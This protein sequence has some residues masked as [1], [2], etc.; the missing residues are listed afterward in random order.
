MADHPRSSYVAK[1]LTQSEFIFSGSAG[2]RTPGWHM[3]IIEEVTAFTTHACYYMSQHDGD[4][5]NSQDGRGM[6]IS[7]KQ[8]YV[9]NKIPTG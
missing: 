6:A 4:D 2:R 5:G 9:M 1:W 8:K 7:K 3:K